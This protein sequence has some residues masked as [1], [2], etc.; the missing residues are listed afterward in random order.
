MVGAQGLL[1]NAQRP[2]KLLARRVVVAG[3]RQAPAEV[4]QWDSQV[5]VIRSPGLLDD[6]DGALES[7][8]RK[9]R[10]AGCQLAAPQVVEN[11]PH[12]D[13]LRPQRPLADAE[14]P[15]ESGLR[16]GAISGIHSSVSKELP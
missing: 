6:G 7:R 16:R 2:L 15:V 14:R 1:L 9:L 11:A 3:R 12:R 13:V 10:F 4:H 5:G 8:Y